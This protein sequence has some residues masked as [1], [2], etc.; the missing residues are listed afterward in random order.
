MSPSDGAARLFG[1]DVRLRNLMALAKY[2]PLRLR[3]LRRVTGA[4]TVHTE[5]RDYA[6]FGRAD[7]VRTWGAGRD[8]TAMLDPN[9]PV[10]LPLRIL[11]IALERAYPLPPQTLIPAPL[12][13]PAMRPWKGDK[14]ALFGSPIPTA[15]LTSIGVMGWTFEAL[16]V[17]VATGYDR[18]VV[19]KVIRRLED[20]GVLQG[21]RDRKPGFNVRVLTISNEFPAHEELLGLLKACVVAWPHVGSKV[22]HAMAQ[23]S[24]RTKEHLRRR[25]LMPSTQI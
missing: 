22:E 5:G 24:A 6:P 21:D 3:D 25:G 13:L 2:G 17:E 11:L 7:L 16:C 15:I 20:E 19:K 8:R 18:V 12:E 4:T 14:L 23:L 10:A 1:P 9:F